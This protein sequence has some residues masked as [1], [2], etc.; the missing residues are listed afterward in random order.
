MSKVDLQ[1]FNIWSS[2][3]LNEKNGS[4][5]YGWNKQ[6]FPKSSQ[7]YWENLFQKGKII[8]TKKVNLSTNKTCPKSSTNLFKNELPSTPCKLV[9]VD[10]KSTREE[11]SRMQ[12]QD[13]YE[14]ICVEHKVHLDSIVHSVS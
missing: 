13:S 7:L 5:F 9:I 11:W 14:I 10:L 3:P 4:P 6:M 8:P 12:G 2:R 1:N